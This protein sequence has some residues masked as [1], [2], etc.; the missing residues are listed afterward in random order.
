[1]GAND[2]LIRNFESLIEK[3]KYEVTNTGN[4]ISFKINN[5]K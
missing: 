3:L 4:K 5:N 1:M 2:K